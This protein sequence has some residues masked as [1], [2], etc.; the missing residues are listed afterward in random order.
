MPL[1]KVENNGSCRGWI[2][3]RVC[4]LSLFTDDI[5]KDDWEYSV[6]RRQTGISIGSCC[7]H[8]SAPKELVTPP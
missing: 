5:V 6:R 2:S 7:I 3:F 8:G 1:G 4:S